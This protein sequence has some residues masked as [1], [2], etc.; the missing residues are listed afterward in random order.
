[1]S[2]LITQAQ[3]EAAV[4]A[5]TVATLTGSDA[6][7]IA[8]RLAEASDW[9]QEYASA[10]GVVLTSG[11]ITAALAYRCA[12]RATFTAAQLQQQFR[13]QTGDVP[14]TKLHDQ[15]VKELE[16]WARRVRP[17]SDDTLATAPE[18]LSD[19]ARGW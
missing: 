12:I 6:D 2:A 4:G 3:W 17:K 16:A 5:T 11:T 7:V 15:A 9:L 1:M 18:V 14:F 10:A 13:G 19:D 8:A